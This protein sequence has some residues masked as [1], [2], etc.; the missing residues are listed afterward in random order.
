MLD[1]NVLAHREIHDRI[2]GSIV[3]SG[4]MP[5]IALQQIAD[6]LGAH[7]NHAWMK[8]GF[9]DRIDD[10][11]IDALSQ[12]AADAIGWRCAIEVLPLGGA[13]DRVDPAETAF[14]HRGSKY[15]FNVIGL[16]EDAA[17]TEA[18]IRWVRQAYAAVEP[19]M[20]GGVYVNYMGGD[21]TGGV[22]AAYGG[23]EYLD[24]LR[25]LKTRYDPA[26]LFCYNFN[27]K[28]LAAA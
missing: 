27:I 19:F 23:S 6:E 21:E 22:E 5:F 1:Y 13:I 9:F 8:A 20:T 25:A 4:V 18:G 2:G 26:N 11:L 24:R 15:V 16:W 3:F 14:A 17:D 28:P 12:A 10:G 7:G